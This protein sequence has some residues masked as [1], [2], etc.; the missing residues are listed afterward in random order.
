MPDAVDVV[1]AQARRRR[2][3][4]EVLAVGRPL[5]ERR[6]R[7]LDGDHLALLLHAPELHVALGDVAEAACEQQRAKPVVVDLVT[8]ARA[9]VPH[10][11]AAQV[12]HRDLNAEGLSMLWNGSPKPQLFFSVIHFLVTYKMSFEDAFQ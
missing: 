5:E 4:E 1:D 10:H 7:H 6:V 2:R 12:E 3:G 9:E 11:V 8:V